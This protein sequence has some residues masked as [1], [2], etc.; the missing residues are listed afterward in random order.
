M[1]GA[2]TLLGYTYCHRGR[3][4]GCIANEA[5]LHLQSSLTKYRSYNYIRFQI[6]TGSR[7][8]EGSSRRAGFCQGCTR[9]SFQA[10]IGVLFVSCGKSRTRLRTGQIVS[11]LRRNQHRVL[12]NWGAISFHPAAQYN[13]DIEIV[14]RNRGTELRKPI[15][16]TYHRLPLLSLHHGGLR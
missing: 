13:K 1:C 10:V 4:I 7:Y 11:S 16:V 5:I 6:S 14:N 8:T 2:E 15:P 3:S 9:P 12:P